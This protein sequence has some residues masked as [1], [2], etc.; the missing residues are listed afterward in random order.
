MDGFHTKGRVTGCEHEA[1]HIDRC[2]SALLRVVLI[3][4]RATCVRDMVNRRLSL[5]NEGRQMA[6]R[7]ASWV[8][9]CAIDFMASLVA[10]S[11]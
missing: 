10:K 6:Q 7:V 5:D 11:T 2:G 4:S 8:L 1:Y 3:Q 9:G